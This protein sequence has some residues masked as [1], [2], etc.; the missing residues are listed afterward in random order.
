MHF[1][2]VCQSQSCFD[3]F[4]QQISAEVMKYMGIT[5]TTEMSSGWSMDDHKT[6]CLELFIDRYGRAYDFF[7]ACFEYLNNNNHNNNKNF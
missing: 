6:A 3:I 2:F 1:L 4:K 5:E 7:P